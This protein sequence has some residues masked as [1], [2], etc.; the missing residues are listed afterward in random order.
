MLGTFVQ[1]SGRCVG[2]D[3]QEKRCGQAARPERKLSTRRFV[4]V[5]CRFGS[6]EPLAVFPPAPGKATDCMPPPSLQGQTV[7]LVVQQTAYN[8][9]P[10]DSMHGE[11]TLFTSISGGDDDNLPGLQNTTL[12]P[13]K[14][15]IEIT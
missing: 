10:T 15:A 4:P 12:S 5:R 2:G 7:R 1:D 8:Y 6:Q 3:I 11:V 14:P 13:T 9:L